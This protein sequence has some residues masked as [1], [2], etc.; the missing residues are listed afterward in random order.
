MQKYQMIFLNGLQFSGKLLYRKCLVL[1]GCKLTPHF[2][3][4]ELGEKCIQIQVVSEFLL[5]KIYQEKK[6]WH[7]ERQLM[8]CE[9][10]NVGV[11]CF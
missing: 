11:G 2:S 8:K 10:I 6:V 7:M 4:D 5:Q 3:Y 9:F 1:C